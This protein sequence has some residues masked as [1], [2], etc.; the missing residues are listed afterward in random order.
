MTVVLQLLVLEGWQGR[1]SL[2]LS[3]IVPLYAGEILLA[4]R[5]RF[6]D[7][8]LRRPGFWLAL[9][10]API[11]ATAWY[12]NARR[13]AVGIH[14][15]ILFIGRSKWSPWPNWW[16]WGGLAASGIVLLVLAAA[17]MIVDGAA[18]DSRR[19]PH[20]PIPHVV[21]RNVRLGL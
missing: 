1:Y 9:I 19:D 11:H 5:G 7:I 14:G 12:I 15:P 17:S 18:D 20:R 21:A 10:T 13:Y 6:G 3:M 8:A 2:P 4:G 16:I